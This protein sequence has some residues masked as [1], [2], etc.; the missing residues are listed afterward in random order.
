MV[1]KPRHI[2]QFEVP[3]ILEI[4]T[5][6]FENAPA[7][8]TRNSFMFG[9]AI[10]AIISGIEKWQD[11]DI[12]TAQHEY[13][14]LFSRFAE[15][16][17]WIQLKTTE[18]AKDSSKKTN[19]LISGNDAP[20]LP[21][22]HQ[23]VFEESIDKARVNIIKARQHNNIIDSIIELLST[24]DFT[25]CG[26]AVD[27][28]GR[29]FEFVPHGYQDCV[30]G[31]L[32]IGPSPASGVKNLASRLEKYLNRGWAMSAS[33]ES[34]RKAMKRPLRKL[35]KKRDPRP[36]TGQHPRF[37]MSRR[38]YVSGHI[39][40]YV[41][42]IECGSMKPSTRMMIGLRNRVRDVML[43]AY[44]IR[45]TI[46][47][48]SAA[49]TVIIVRVE[50]STPR[51]YGFGTAHKPALRALAVANEYIKLNHWFTKPDK[52]TYGGRIY[53]ETRRSS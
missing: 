52:Q 43:D 23:A 24:V 21:M 40:E 14:V 33:M 28:R 12:V 31:I 51:H 35:I 25:C 39:F 37:Y 3:H 45:A 53:H 4:L 8:M 42:M 5:E 17:K 50:E 19:A 9:G 46:I 27:R 20:N 47:A 29:V 36:K 30:D 10:N 16:P 22:T 26:V 13:D 38:A 2:K 48:D 44:G 41:P 49:N 1:I 15:S 6:R 18:D 34:M 7:L 32:R 11:L